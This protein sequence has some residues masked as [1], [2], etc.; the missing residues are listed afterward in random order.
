[1]LALPVLVASRSKP[2][3]KGKEMSDD[4][5]EKDKTLPD[6]LFHAGAFW[7]WAQPHWLR[8]GRAR[9]SSNPEEVFY[10]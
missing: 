10:A 6:R 9:G 7:K 4:K 8:L 1:M 2:V 3:N 5:D